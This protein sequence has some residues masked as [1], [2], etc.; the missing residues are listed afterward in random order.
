MRGT[1]HARTTR[2][3]V[4]TAFPH[5]RIRLVCSRRSRRACA[6]ARHDR[7]RGV[8]GSC[9]SDPDRRRR[10][11]GGGHCDSR[12]D[13]HADAGGN[14]NTHA[15]ADAGGNG[16]NTHAHADAGGK[17]TPTPTPAAFGAEIVVQKIIDN[18]GNFDT[19]DD[20]TAAEGWEF[21]L[22]L[23]EGTIDEA[24]P[25]TGLDGFARWLISS[26]P[27]GTSAT[28]TE[29]V[30]EDF[31]LDNVSCTKITESGEQ[32][33]IG[34]SDNIASVSFQVDEGEFASY[35]CSF[36]NI[37]SDIRRADI[38]VRKHI[39]TDGDLKTLDDQ[40]RPAWEFEAAFE[41]DVDILFA[42]P[43]AD[44]DG[45]AS[46]DISHTG[47]FTRVVVTEVPQSGYQLVKASCFDA[48]DALATEIATTLDGN[49]LSF[50]VSGFGLFAVAPHGYQCDF[51]NT[52]V[53]VA[54]LPTLPPT[55][56]AIGSAVVGSDAW[57]LV[58]V[59]LAAIVVGGLVLGSRLTAPGRR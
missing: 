57:R 33:P 45:F 48:D 54:A 22:E 35:Q 11:A 25:L 46:W 44:R 26:G 53:G 8:R 28:V 55:D 31:I 52:P 16:N 3:L 15:H 34:L 42:D 30:Q 50:Y 19:V 1:H 21:E 58:L 20:R 6:P 51:W 13:A 29:V 43:D 40:V 14:A 37:R 59:G 24:F 10:P 5:S 4:E 2:R 39:D 49:R 36:L 41:S 9:R 23:P 12:S 18:D 7:R 32:S 17:A 47:D 27:G 56:A 38:F